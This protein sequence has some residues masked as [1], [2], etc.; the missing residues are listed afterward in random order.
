MVIFAARFF[1]LLISFLTLGSSAQ[2]ATDPL[3]F[4]AW[5]ERFA[6]DWVRLSPEY[7]TS[8]RYFPAEEQ[9]RLD[10]QSSVVGDKQREQRLALAKAGLAQADAYLTTSLAP[11]QRVNALT[12]R[13]SLSNAIDAAAFEDHRFV[14]NQNFGAQVRYQS[15]FAENQPLRRAADLP[16]F[17]ARLRAMPQ[18]IEQEL[19]QAQRSVARGFLPPRFIAQRARMQL[20]LLL[21]SPLAEEPAV[22]GFTRRVAAI[23]NLDAQARE[24]AVAE[25]QKTVTQE[26]RPAWARV[27]TFLDGLV[28]RAGDDAG[29]WRLSGGA[30]AYAQALQSNTTT[31]M[32]ADEIHQLGLR[33]VVRI[34][35][36][37][38]LVLVRMGRS[39]GSV[40]QRV[41]ALRVENQ[42]PAVP[43]PRPM[44]LQRYTEMVADATRRS[45]ALFNLQPAAGIEVRRVGPL[46]ERTASASYTTPAP[47][48]SRP[49]VFW[50]PMPGPSFDTLRMRSL[51]VHEAV[52]GHHFQL[53]LQQEN[54]ALPKWRQLRVF[55]GGSAHSEGWALYAERLAIEQ[56]WY[57][58]DDKSLL[59]ALDGQLFRARRLVVDTGLHAKRW[60]RQQA[61]DYGIGAQEVERYV[62]NPGQ[63]CAYMVG[64]LRIV[65]LRDEARAALGEHFS[66]RE[67]HDLV[68]KTGSV[69]L[70]V[71]GDVVRHWLAQQRPAQG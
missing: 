27:A 56:A 23:P 20:R 28:A 39:V 54:T 6:E 60:T 55:G 37:M 17:M 2:G 4:A 31:R 38:D 13:W 33:E 67:F 51:A 61:I 29:L 10:A 63:A 36:E 70:D 34:E 64:M 69:P 35:R 52:P 53:A 58:G 50:V 12:L 47:D 15:L 26:V 32:T 19:S 24:R 25:V 11:D 62:A 8:L 1:A 65:A 16:A 14:F 9:A 45:Q 71:L 48:G 43:D 3:P 21:E 18:R 57:E 41:E 49:A 22:A 66:L 46:T 30:A 5:S 44:L 42:P 7:S 59:G 68:L 40:A